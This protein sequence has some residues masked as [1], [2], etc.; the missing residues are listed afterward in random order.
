MNHH[1]NNMNHPKLQVEQLYGA[2]I[3]MYLA[4]ILDAFLYFFIYFR[5]I[6]G[7]PTSFF[8]KAKTFL[9]SN[10]WML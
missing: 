6:I 3:I 9:L 7:S 10:N 5:I 1:A 8:N 2:Q 4:A